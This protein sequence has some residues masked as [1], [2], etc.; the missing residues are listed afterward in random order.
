M[1]IGRGL[2]SLI[3]PKEGEYKNSSFRVPMETKSA[4]IKNARNFEIPLILKTNEIPEENYQHK[5]QR[6][7][8]SHESVFHIEIEKIKPNPYQPRRE[9]GEADLKELTQSIVEFGIIQPILVSKITTETEVGTI[10]AYQ[11]IAGERR[12]K[13]AKIAGLE[14]IP[15]IVKKIDSNKEKLELALIENLQRSDLSPIESAR[16]YSK[17][18]EEFGLTQ[19]EIASRVGKS[20]EVIANSLRLLGL[21]S[22]IQEALMKNKINESQA[23]T[24]LSFQNVEEQKRIFEKLIKGEINTRVLREQI[25]P[26]NIAHDSEQSF[27]EKQLEEKLGSPVKLTKQGQKGKIII[28]F[29]SQGELQSILNTIIGE[30]ELSI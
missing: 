18:Q 2:Q 12:L 16:A 11:L 3:P 23:R 19:R 14:R 4:E 21:P 15:A 20:R 10:V 5:K 28:H 6:N 8:R 25:S 24:L 22:H 17:L 13:A 1:T 9:F 29:Y 7:Q 26:K 27:W 30:D